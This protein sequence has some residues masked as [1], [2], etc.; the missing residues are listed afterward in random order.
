M[1]DDILIFIPNEV[2]SYEL[3]V[4]ITYK[5]EKGNEI[6]KELYEDIDYFKIENKWCL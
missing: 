3:V 1:N 5:D 6:N 4:I 2:K